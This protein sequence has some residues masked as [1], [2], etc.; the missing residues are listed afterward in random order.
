[1]QACDHDMKS[2]SARSF[3][4]IL[5]IHD[6]LNCQEPE[7]VPLVLRR[8][9]SHNSIT[10]GDHGHSGEAWASTARRSGLYRIFGNNM[11]TTSLGD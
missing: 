6:R 7:P 9:K 2:Q 5:K 1:M 4:A 10:V 3:D 8:L 11:L